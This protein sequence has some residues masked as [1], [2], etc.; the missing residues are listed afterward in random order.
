MIG[1]ARPAVNVVSP[2]CGSLLDGNTFGE[3][4]VWYNG[5]QREEVS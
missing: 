5:D 4:C 2:V 1:L 3:R